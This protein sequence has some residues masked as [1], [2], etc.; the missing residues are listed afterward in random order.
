MEKNKTNKQKVKLSVNTSWCLLHA[1][2]KHVNSLFTLALASFNGVFRVLE[3]K[4]YGTLPP[5]QK[6]DVSLK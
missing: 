3:C 2:L 4:P 6:N 1:I 5:F